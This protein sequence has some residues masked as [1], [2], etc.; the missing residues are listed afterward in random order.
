MTGLELVD[1]EGKFRDWN[2]P[3]LANRLSILTTDH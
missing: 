2:D 1:W 3:A